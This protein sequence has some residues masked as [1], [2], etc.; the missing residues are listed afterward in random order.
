MFERMLDKRR[1]PTLSEIR[2]YI[3]ETAYTRLCG[4]ENVRAASLFP[5]DLNRLEP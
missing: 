1:A 5:R 3:G 4:L 2:A